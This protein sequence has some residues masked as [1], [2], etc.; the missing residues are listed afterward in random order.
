[1][2]CAYVILKFHLISLRH[3]TTSTFEFTRIA[4][5]FTLSSPRCLDVTKRRASIQALSFKKLPYQLLQELCPLFVFS[6]SLSLQV[7]EDILLS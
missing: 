5:V 4:S 2:I 1:M 6:L 3:N 7:T